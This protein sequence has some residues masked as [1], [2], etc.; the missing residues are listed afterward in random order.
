MNVTTSRQFST[1]L[2]VT[3]A[4]CLGCV[5][6]LPNV[7]SLSNPGEFLIRNTVRLA[8]FYWVIAVSVRARGGMLAACQRVAWTLACIAYLVHV[9][10]AFEHAHH[11]SHTVAFEHVRQA[12]GFGEGIYFNYLFTIVWTADALWWWVDRVAYENRSRWLALIIHGFMLF[13]IVNGAIIFE[14]GPIRWI[15]T[16]MLFGLGWQFWNKRCANRRSRS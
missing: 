12:G 1:L 6:V 9:G 2:F 10:M 4:M 8:L 7:I 5:L 14:Q 3:W 13:M 11:W 16:M 15:G